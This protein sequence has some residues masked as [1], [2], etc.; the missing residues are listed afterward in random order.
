[1]S[2]TSKIRAC[3]A[4][5]VETPDYMQVKIGKEKIF[6]CREHWADFVDGL[7]PDLL[8]TLADSQR[9]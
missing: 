1:M 6:F 3:S 5:D 7:E 8:L 9:P 4:C 2:S